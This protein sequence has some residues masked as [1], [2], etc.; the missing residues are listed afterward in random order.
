MRP[1]RCRSDRRQQEPRLIL[2]VTQSPNQK[3]FVGASQPH[4]EADRLFLRRILIGLIAATFFSGVVTV[5]LTSQ[6]DGS[7]PF[8][9]ATIHG[10]A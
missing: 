9:V 6:H 1:N 3:Q 10:P 2:A 4:G 7:E 5:A 8:E